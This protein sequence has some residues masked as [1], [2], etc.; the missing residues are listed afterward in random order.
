VIVTEDQQLEHPLGVPAGPASSSSAREAINDMVE[1]GLLDELMGRVDRDG[2]ALTGV[3]GFLP[4][5]V[6]AVLERGLAT[7]LTEHLGYEKGDPAGRGSPNSRNGSTPKTLATEVGEIPLQVPRDR[8]G[9]FEPRLVPKGAR[10]AGGLDE[11]IIS[12]YAGGMTVRDIQ[13]HLARTLGTELS[14]ETISKITEQVVDEV[15]AW[16]SRPLEEIYP[17]IYLD[18]LVVK[19]RDGHQVRNKAAHIA[20]GVDLDGIKHVLGIWV[21]ASEGAKFWAGVCAE[22]RNRGVRDVLIVCCDGLTG[23]PEAIEATWPQ[24]TVQ[25]CTV[26]LLRAAMRFVSYTDRKKVAAALRPIY[27]APTVEAAETELLAFAESDLGR[28]YPATVATWENAWERFIPFLAFPPELRKIIYTTNSIESLNY[29]LR[30][31]IKNRGHFPTDDAVIKLLW[32]AIRDIEDKR[33][34]QRASER[35]APRDQRKAPGRLVEGAVV[36]GWK[37]ALGALALAYPDR[38]T[39]YIA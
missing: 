31:I 3:G 37:A 19:V 11:M 27:T 4:E 1:A 29:Q 22:L 30:K 15:K 18:A 10:R 14:H 23:F 6:K 38:L 20:V 26:H 21:Q 32:L 35:G 28:R 36:Q 5:L 7:E 39:P 34:R 13:H 2:L 12:L 16:Q 17:I 33:A 8:A 9:T 25:T 24:A